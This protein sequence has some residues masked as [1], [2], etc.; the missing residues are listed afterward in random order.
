[1]PATIV[2]T[3][4]IAAHAAS[5]FVTSLSAERD[6][7]EVDLDRGRQHFADALDRRVDP[8]Q[9]VVDVAEVL[10][11][12]GA[13]LRHAPAVQPAGRLHQRVDRVLQHHELLL[14]RV[15][16]L[17]VRA[18]R[19]ALEDLLLD[20]LE[21]GLERVDHREVAVDDVVHHRVEHVARAVA[22]A[23]R[24]RA[25]C[26]R[27]RRRSRRAS[28]AG[29]TARSWGRRRCR[30]R[31]CRGRRCRRR[32]SRARSC[33]ARRTA[34]RRTPR[35][36]AA[37][38]RGARRRRRARAGRTPPPSRR[39]PR[40][41][42]SNSATQTKQSGRLTYSLMSSLGMSASLRAVLV[43]D[44]ADEH[45]GWGMPYGGWPHHSG[46]VGARPS[47][48]RPGVGAAVRRRLERGSRG[49]GAGPRS[50]RL[51]YCK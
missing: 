2:G 22:S 40:C 4:M 31:R 37:G 51:L 24:A 49:D 17:D 39:A 6:H 26:A 15:E 33:A 43:G 21:L 7:A 48:A 12:A 9:V 14:Q 11:H 41:D 27:A 50:D 5:F 16:R 1:M 35:S 42:G 38:G 20:R 10:V 13:D 47:A 36:W 32:P 44:A 29:P 23:A 45:G 19:V 30:P 28:G 34:S 3:A 18:R 25:R 46:A 8:V